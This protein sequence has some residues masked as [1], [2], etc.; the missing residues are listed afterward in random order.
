MLIFLHLSL[1]MKS[2]FFSVADKAVNLPKIT[3]YIKN[4]PN[5]F[6][7]D[8]SASVIIINQSVYKALPDRPRLQ[9]PVPNIYICGSKTSLSV[10][11]FF[12]KDT[13]YKSNMT[14]A[15]F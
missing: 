13:S 10:L 11:L 8:T 2:M 3:A 5:D 9:S 4:I 14:G 12:S 6:L 1:M 15:K 7:I